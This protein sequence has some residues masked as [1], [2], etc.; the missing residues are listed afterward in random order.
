MSEY[1]YFYVIGSNKPFKKLEDIVKEDE[2][3]LVPIKLKKDN[4]KYKPHLMEIGG[5]A[6][7]ELIKKL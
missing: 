4:I 5:H 7:N 2:V 6:L 3:K 1:Y